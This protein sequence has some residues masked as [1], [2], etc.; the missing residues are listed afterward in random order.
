VGWLDISEYIVPIKGVLL[1]SGDHFNHRLIVLA[2]SDLIYIN[3]YIDKGSKNVDI[4]Y[5]LTVWVHVGFGALT[6]A[7]FW[8]QA[9]LPKGSQPHIIFGRIFLVSGALVS[10]S[11]IY[12]ILHQLTN[13]LIQVKSISI[14]SSDFAFAMI[15]AFI[16]VEVLIML[17]RGQ[18]SAQQSHSPKPPNLRG[19][20][21]RLVTS[22]LATI[23]MTTLAFFGDSDWLAPMLAASILGAKITYDEFYILRCH[24]SFQEG[25]WKAE[26]FRGMIG[27]GISFHVAFGINGIL[28]VEN[29][30]GQAVSVGILIAAIPVILGVPIEVL[31]RRKYKSVGTKL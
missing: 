5:K 19:L 23:G 25:D 22:L 2:V 28:R 14:N 9:I 29:M 27:A 3:I 11:A 17:H 10:M 13:T 6:I 1:G 18:F 30:L 7:L 16:A 12:A 4:I 26:H 31:L 24:Q 21:L 15:L 8:L 20:Y